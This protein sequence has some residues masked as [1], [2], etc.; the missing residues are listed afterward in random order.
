MKRNLIKFLKIENF[1]EYCNFMINWLESNEIFVRN[2]Y[3]LASLVLLAF[4]I[5]RVELAIDAANSAEY[6]ADEAKNEAESA[7]SSAND[8]ERSAANAESA[9]EFARLFK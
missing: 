3:R 7:S 6:S 5:C 1:Y 8:A 4:L 2:L 9:C